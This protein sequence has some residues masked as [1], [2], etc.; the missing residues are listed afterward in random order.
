MGCAAARVVKRCSSLVVCACSGF[1]IGDAWSFL[2]S[3]S[4]FN[5][6]P[7]AGIFDVSPKSDRASSNVETPCVVSAQA[8]GETGLR[9]S[10]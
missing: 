2:T 4:K 9:A 7:N 3:A 5:I 8:F 6:E 10:T 1:H